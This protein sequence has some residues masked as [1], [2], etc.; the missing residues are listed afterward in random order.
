MRNGFITLSVAAVATLAAVPSV[1]VQTVRA[2]E[3]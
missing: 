2:E 3:Y 1:R